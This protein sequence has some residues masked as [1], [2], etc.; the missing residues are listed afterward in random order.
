MHCNVPWCACGGVEPLW[1]CGKVI[2]LGCD[3]EVIFV[4]YRM[5]G[6]GRAVGICCINTF[7]G[8]CVKAS[9]T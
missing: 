9:M 6:D 4:G 1:D 2:V 8:S 3:G 7:C 5:A